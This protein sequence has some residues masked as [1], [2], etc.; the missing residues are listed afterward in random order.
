MTISVKM[1]IMDFLNENDLKE[2]P[3]HSGILVDLYKRLG[4]EKDFS[5]SNL[6]DILKIAEYILGK[7]ELRE[8]ESEWIDSNIGYF[9]KIA[10]SA[11]IARM[12]AV[13]EEM[14]SISEYLQDFHDGEFTF[15]TVYYFLESIILYADRHYERE[16]K[17]LLNYLGESM[18]IIVTT[19]PDIRYKS[20]LDEEYEKKMKELFNTHIMTM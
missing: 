10:N 20:N 3:R 8:S 15:R 16:T 7:S 13:P 11:H 2:F 4:Y 17:E 18:S 6:I 19:F 14:Q 12:Q 5:L 9:R 1:S